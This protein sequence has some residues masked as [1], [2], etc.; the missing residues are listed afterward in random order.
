MRLS[1]IVNQLIIILPQYTDRFSDLA[2]IASISSSTTEAI[3]TTTEAHGLSDNDS[4]TLANVVFHNSI[5]AVS[6]DGLVFTFTT[7]QPHDL[8]Q[9]WN[10]TIT[11]AGFTD[12]EW[13]ASFSLVAV[14]DRNTF[15]VQSTN[16]LPTL[17]GAEY[18]SEIRIDGLNGRFPAIV[19]SDTTFTISGDFLQGVYS[20]GKVL[21]GV[22][23]AGI[24]DFDR[25]METYTEQSP[26]DLWMFVQMHDIE[27]SRDRESLTD[28]YAQKSVKSNDF[29][30]SLI[31]GFNC[32]IIKSTSDEVA[33]VESVDI[34][35]H[36]IF[37]PMMKTIFGVQFDSGLSCEDS[38]GAMLT[39]TS[40]QLYNGAYLVYSYIFEVSYRLFNDDVVEPR[41]TRA[42]RNI[43]YRE[44]VGKGNMDVNI[45]LDGDG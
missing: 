32:H 45:N 36:E 1:D 21:K 31:D 38:Y 19:T 2:S 18:L 5:T 33:A 29:R 8:T 34:T 10:E 41:N 44:V 23:I 37:L 17:S 22:R 7:S 12:N 27:T 16:S 40:T 4:V 39:G 15:S 25:A 20:S 11:L 3:I 6:R 43:E 9:N 35:R 26:N 30:M 13:N 24:V 14:P 28:A 42:F